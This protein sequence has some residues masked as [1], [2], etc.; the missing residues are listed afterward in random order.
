MRPPPVP[1]AADDRLE[2]GKLRL[3]V[4]IALDA[5]RA[6]HQH[7]GITGTPRHFA[8][9]NRVPGHAASRLDNFA[10]AI[11]AA[12][13]DIVDELV[14]LTHSIEQQNMRACAIA[15]MDVNTYASV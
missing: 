11:A 9:G 13:A 2:G 4:Q 5:A 8:R 14:A 10:D 6:R 15:F 1:R 3:P 7:G 12:S